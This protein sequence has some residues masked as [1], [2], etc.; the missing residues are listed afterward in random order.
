MRMPPT[1]VRGILH[2]DI[3]TVTADTIARAGD[4]Q[5]ERF[6]SPYLAIKYPWAFSSSAIRT[7]P[8]AAPRTV[9]WLRATNL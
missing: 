5:R 9:L 3:F 6:S 8:P 2:S 4:T 7:A 1:G